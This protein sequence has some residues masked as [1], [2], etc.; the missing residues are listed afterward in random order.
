VSARR[1]GPAVALLLACH[2]VG[3]LAAQA[4]E[5]P[6]SW[7]PQLLGAQFTFIGQRLAPFA[8]PYSG[9]NSLI[10]TGDTE[11]THTYGA[12][13]GARLA[14]RLEAY[15]DVEMARGAS[16]G[17]AVGLAGVTN[18]DVIRQGSANLGLGP[19]LARA[20][21]KYIIPLSGSTLQADRAMDQ[22]P[23]AEPASRI[24]LKAGK[25]AATDDFDQNSYAN[26]TRYQFCDWGLFNNTA[27]DYAADTRGYSN[28][29]MVGWIHPHWALRLG[30]YQM[31]TFANG[32]VF[33][34]DVR[35]ARGDN[36][37]LTLQP[38]SE[39]GP[40]MRLLAYQNHAR[41]GSYAEA[42][43][44]AQASGQLPDI[45]ADDQPGR[46]KYGAG[47]NVEQP[48]A[49][50]G[51]TGAFL[52][53]GWNDGHTEDFA[54]SEV[55][56]HLSGG[57]QLAGSRWRRAADR[58][59]LGYVLHGLSRDHEAYLA[60]GGTG[61]LLGDG[62][63]DYGPEEIFEAYYRAQLGRYVEVSPDIQHISHP[64]YNR[65]RG[66]VTLMT[67]RLNVRY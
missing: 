54:F 56:R 44:R 47:L 3:R 14:S 30:S 33:D 28:G 59:G 2:A 46:R 17:H 64:G 7:A 62:R 58:L 66:P 16:V 43:A 12:Y 60:A 45:A 11:A 1:A 34:G 5:A 10:N 8:A 55:D 25:L 67:L 38:G 27:W 26:S 4:P 63:L 53:A 41:M 13:L 6:P 35:H 52:R 23:G 20:F 29:V 19:Y 50:S 21:L 15:V 65:A 24:E 48:L 49:D 22:L 31:P 37:E 42:L 9:P 39:G 18:G 40:T 51:Q 57:V 36:V 61:F 32:N